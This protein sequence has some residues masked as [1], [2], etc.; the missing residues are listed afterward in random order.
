MV[1]F[2]FTLIL[3]EFIEYECFIGHASPSVFVSTNKTVK[4]KMRFIINIV[5]VL[6]CQWMRSFYAITSVVGG[7]IKETPCT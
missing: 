4:I 3:K 2:L 6:G 5:D 7:I 1:G